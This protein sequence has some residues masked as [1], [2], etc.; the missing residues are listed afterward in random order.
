MIGSTS[1]R[2]ILPGLKSWELF[3]LKGLST[4]LPDVSVAH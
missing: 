1:F 3:I 2:E 4:P